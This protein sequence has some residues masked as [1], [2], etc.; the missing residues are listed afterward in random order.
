[1]VYGALVYGA[2]VYAPS[3]GVRAGQTVICVWLL[4]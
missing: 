4:E 3:T 2:L 1:V